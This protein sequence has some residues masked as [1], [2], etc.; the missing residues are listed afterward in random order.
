LETPLLRF[1]N[2]L[3][4]F[5]NEIMRFTTQLLEF[6]NELLDFETPLLEFQ[7]EVMRFEDAIFCQSIRKM[8]LVKET[9]ALQR[10]FVMDKFKNFYY[11]VWGAEAQR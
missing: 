5:T 4:E 11:E 7:N 9:T 2:Q 8:R 6:T 3:L 1:T 10:V